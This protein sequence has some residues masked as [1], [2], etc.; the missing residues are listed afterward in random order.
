MG[1]LLL[2]ALA[3]LAACSP[4]R[5]ERADTDPATQEADIRVCR[6]SAHRAYNAMSERLLYPPDVMIVEDNKGRLREVPVAPSRQFGPTVWSPY[7]S[8]SALDHLTLRQDLFEHCL[9]QKGYRLVPDQEG[10]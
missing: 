10:S 1:C 9:Q 4:V 5:W 7:T 2:S 8:R 6:G 3:T